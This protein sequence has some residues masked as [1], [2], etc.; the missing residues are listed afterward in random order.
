MVT[1]V[2]L[3]LSLSN[4]FLHGQDPVPAVSVCICTGS[5][6]LHAG[7]CASAL[8]PLWH[9]ILA[10]AFAPPLSGWL[11]FGRNHPLCSALVLA[12][13]LLETCLLQITCYEM[14]WGP[15]WAWWRP[16][17]GSF[18]SSCFVGLTSAD[19]P[20]KPIKHTRSRRVIHLKIY[21]ISINASLCDTSKL[22]AKTKL[23]CIH[24]NCKTSNDRKTNKNS[25]VTFYS[26]CYCYYEG[27]RSSDIAS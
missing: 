2:L 5:V 15:G 27:R 23:G 18:S 25:T 14:T 6:Y 8:I 13:K 3:R 11:M 9:S 20:T 1:K 12:S 19:L 16:L 4:P 21:G 26:H 10:L 7:P 22:L 24:P 17:P